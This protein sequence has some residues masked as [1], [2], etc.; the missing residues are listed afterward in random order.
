VIDTFTAPSKTFTDIKNGH[1]S[2]WMPFVIMCVFGYIFFAVV[3]AKIGM[4]QVVDNQMKLASPAQQERAAN[5]TPEQK[6][7]Q[8]KFA[9]Y[10]TE[11]AFLAGPLF[12]IIMG[13]IIALVLWG[14]I[15]FAFGGKAQF[16]SVLS[17]WMYAMLPGLIKVI[18]G[19]IVIFAGA[20]PESFNIRNFSPT[21]LGAFLDPASTNKALYALASGIDI[22]TI[23]TLVL[24]GIGLA[25][26]ASVKRS[27]G[28][29][30]VF[31]WWIV[32]LLFSVGWNAIMG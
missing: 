18:L 14:T 4:Q 20:A 22:V 5:M 25:I 12:T 15:N 21:N 2:W 8:T 16:G 30:A 11:G 10:F 27:A 32:V 29:I 9:I 28:Y 19:I 7:M 26:V 23:W 3:N 31:G 13:L 17:V 24:M 1:K 6:A